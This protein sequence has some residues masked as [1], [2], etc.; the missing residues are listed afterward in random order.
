MWNKRL[1]MI[2]FIMQWTMGNRYVL[3]CSSHKEKGNSINVYTG[4]QLRFWKVYPERRTDESYKRCNERIVKRA[5]NAAPL[6]GTG[7]T[8]ICSQR[9]IRNG[10]CRRSGTLQFYAQYSI[11]IRS[12]NDPMVVV[13]G[14][15]GLKTPNTASYPQFSSRT[16]LTITD[17]K[18]SREK[19]SW[20]FSTRLHLA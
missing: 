1:R 20:Y 14:I 2:L 12:P 10:L 8:Y 4:F 19:G 11:R 18:V 15:T 3:R 6:I 9:T 5:G 16:Y 13:D 17:I 7:D